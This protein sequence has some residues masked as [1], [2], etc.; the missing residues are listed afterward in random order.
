MR[1]LVKY[2]IQKIIKD[3]IHDRGRPK[4]NSLTLVLYVRY[5]DGTPLPNLLMY[6]YDNS[7]FSVALSSSPKSQILLHHFSL[8]CMMGWDDFTFLVSPKFI[9]EP[10]GNVCW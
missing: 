3:S 2:H 8:T 4:P 5:K 7:R 10:K 6:R 9:S 1:F